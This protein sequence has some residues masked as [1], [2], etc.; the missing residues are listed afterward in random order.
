MPGPLTLWRPF[1]ELDEMRSRLD[2][3]YEQWFDGEQRDWMPAIDVERGKDELT[4]RADIPGFK[5]DEVKIEVQDNVL[6]ISGEQEEQSEAK[7]KTYL[8]RERRHGSFMRSMALP[9]GVD[10]SKITAKTTD[11]VVEVTIPL[12]KAKKEPITITSTAA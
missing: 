1:G 6:T 9:N 2:R 7:E 12:P 11:G 4:V 5:P 10:P 8:R 3:L